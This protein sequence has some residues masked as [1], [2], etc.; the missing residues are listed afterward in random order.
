MATGTTYLATSAAPR[1]GLAAAPT[2]DAV[3]MSDTLV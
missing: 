3:A 1:V 2:A